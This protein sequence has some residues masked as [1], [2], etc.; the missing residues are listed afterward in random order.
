MVTETIPHSV[1]MGASVAVVTLTNRC[2]IHVDTANDAE[3]VVQPERIVTI[4]LGGGTL[5]L[6]FVGLFV[7]GIDSNQRSM[8]PCVMTD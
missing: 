7:C 3:K 1:G 2:W 6:L 5:P 8:V 4:I